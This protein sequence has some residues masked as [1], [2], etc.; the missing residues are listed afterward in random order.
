[1]PP[2]FKFLFR[3]L[4]AIPLTLLIVTAA[5]F[6]I[7]M[8]APVETR[9][10]LYMPNWSSNN[11]NIRPEL[12]LQRVIEEHGLNDPF[13][14]QYGRWVTRL[15]QG[16][17]GWSPGLGDDVLHALLVR[18]PGTVELTLYSILFLVPLGIVGGVLAG[19]R[20]N[21]C[22]DHGFRFVAFIATSIPPFILG[23]VLLSIFY[24]GVRWFP[25]GRLDTMYVFAIADGNFKPYTGL[26]TVDGLLNGQ[27]EISINALRHMV[28]PV[29]TLSLSHW[30]TL[31]RITRAT[32]LEELSKDYI[33]AA[34]GRGITRRSILWLHAL[35]NALIPALNSSAL[36]AA[37]L[38]MGVFVVEAIFGFPGISEL[39]TDSFNYF[40]DTPA[41]LG[42]AI[43]SV[44]LVLPI[45][46]VFDILQGFVDPRIRE[47]IETQ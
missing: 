37:S 26:L 9:A 15:V 10:Q 40:P 8:L 45:M 17:W 18:T 7:V 14:V 6:A 35:R 43:Y 3:R 36:S 41:G 39:I 47:G 19:W 34:H 38:I 20:Q 30:A 25:P 46:L 42:F 4:L 27:L 22:F 5:L 16:E 13:L 2:L 31:G 21:Q 23:L 24:V 32:L 11:P 44:L 33:T 12:V 28:L 29:I 1:M